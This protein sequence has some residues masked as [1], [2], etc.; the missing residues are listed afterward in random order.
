MP[1]ISI[2]SALQLVVGF[3]LLNVWLVRAKSATN[4]RGGDAKTLREEF[5]A[6]GLPEL[7]FYLVGG[8]KIAA[9]AILLAGLWVDLPIRLAAGIVFVL[10]VGAVAMHT[11]VGDPPVRSLPAILMLLMSSGILLLA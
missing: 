1:E 6:Y 11:K 7:A 9:G 2:L 3:G 5:K 4:Y 10:M 8:L